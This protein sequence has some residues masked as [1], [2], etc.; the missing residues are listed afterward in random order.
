MTNNAKLASSVLFYFFILMFFIF[1]WQDFLFSMLELPTSLLDLHCPMSTIQHRLLF[2]PLRNYINVY[3][4]VFVTSSF[5]T[6][7]I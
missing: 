3:N 6:V 4:P 2:L 1:L 5:L 7:V